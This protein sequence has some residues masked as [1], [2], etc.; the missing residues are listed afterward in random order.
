MRTESREWSV[1]VSSDPVCMHYGRALAQQFEV[2]MEVDCTWDE[3]HLAKNRGFWVEEELCRGGWSGQETEEEYAIRAC[4]RLDEIADCTE[5]GR[6]VVVSREVMEAV[7]R[8]EKGLVLACLEYSDRPRVRFSMKS[9]DFHYQPSTQIAI[10][11]MPASVHAAEMHA[12][13][14]IHQPFV[15]SQA[16]TVVYSP[17][18]QNSPLAQAVSRSLGIDLRE[19]T[20]LRPWEAGT[21]S[22]RECEERLQACIS[23][24]R[25]TE[26]IALDASICQKMTGQTSGIAILS[27][28]QERTVTNFTAFTVPSAPSITLICNTDIP[29][30]VMSTLLTEKLPSMSAAPWDIRSCS[31]PACILLAQSIANQ[32]G[33]TC[34]LDYLWDDQHVTDSPEPVRLESML[35]SGE[36]F[37]REDLDQ[38]KAR[39][40]TA[41]G[42]STNSLLVC[43]GKQVFSTLTGTTDSVATLHLSPSNEWTVRTEITLGE[44]REALAA[45]YAGIIAQQVAASLKSAISTSDS[46]QIYKELEKVL[47]SELATLLSTLEN[48]YDSAIKEVNRVLQTEIGNLRTEME[49]RNEEMGNTVEELKGNLS[50]YLEK[51]GKFDVFNTIDNV[52]HWEA[53]LQSLENRFK[54]LTQEFERFYD[55]IPSSELP[56]TIDKVEENW[57]IITTNGHLYRIEDA[58]LWAKCEGVEDQKLLDCISLGPGTSTHNIPFLSS[59]PS[60]SKVKLTWKQRFSSLSPPFSIQILHKSAS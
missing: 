22:E 20:A 35:Y 1:A 16:W 31:S 7:V 56:V 12:N 54:T 3:R 15:Q 27:D 10:I 40:Y 6:L 57:Q 25:G 48:K 9:D 53:T 43:V 14:F 55:F 2:I 30:A 8:E 44:T 29:A 26:I 47:S 23:Q 37:G 5:R 39:I 42:L 38:F 59:F 49:R 41:T 58:D 52:K 28:S 19:M 11:S 51:V 13:C 21:E 33:L 24:L 32:Y 45:Y 4:D 46:A 50:D 18:P 17:D 34:T 36:W 60:N